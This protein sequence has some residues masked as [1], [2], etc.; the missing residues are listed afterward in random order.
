MH[1]GNFVEIKNSAIG[2]GSK[3]NHLSYVGDTEVGS[4][5]NIGAGTITCNYDGANKWRTRIGD[6]AFIGSGSMLVAPVT[7]G[8]GAT[9]GAG[10]TITSDAPAGKLTLARSRQVTIEQWQRPRKSAVEGLIATTRG[11]SA[12]MC[13]IVGGVTDRNIVPI[14]IEGLK[15][16]EYRGYDS[17]GIA[18]LEHDAASC[19]AC[20][21][22]ARCARSRQALA[23]TADRRAASASPTRAGPRTACR[24]SATRIR[25]SV[26]RRA[27]DRAQRHHRELRGAARA[28]SKRAGYQFSSE[29]D[30]EVVAHRVHFNRAKLG[31]LFKA[32][33]ATVAE[34][35]GAYALAVVSE[36]DPRPHHRRA[37]GLPGGARA[38]RR[39]RTSSPR[40]SPRCCR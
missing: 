24:A 38:G 6:G 13:G 14:L 7:I 11:R 27:R 29:T 33:R 12:I 23:Q 19:N 1:L 17:A 21:R 5:V 18:V 4:D 36:H 9:I 20:A 16:L 26:A 40:T 3:V 28:S 32:V 15:R 34:L 30:T 25:T 37:R 35:E 31:D 22:S 2:A 8:D 39:T 10:S